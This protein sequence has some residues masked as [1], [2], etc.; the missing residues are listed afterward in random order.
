MAVSHTFVLNLKHERFCLAKK[1]LK[2]C[3]SSTRPRVR[4]IFKEGR[5]LRCG[6][7]TV[8]FKKVE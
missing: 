7:A 5:T 4:A 6:M 1:I 3:G 8:H 2:Y